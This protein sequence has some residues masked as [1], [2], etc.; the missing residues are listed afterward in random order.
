MITILALLTLATASRDANTFLN[1]TLQRRTL[2]T[3]ATLTLATLLELS[4]RL[5]SLVTIRTLAPKTLVMQSRESLT[6]LWSTLR[7]KRIPTCATPTLAV[8]ESS[9]RLA[10]NATIMMLALL[11]LA[12][13]Q[14][15]SANTRP[16]NATMETLALLILATQQLESASTFQ[17]LVMMET[18]ALKILA[19]LRP[20]SASSLMSPKS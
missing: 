20:E 11:T 8:R 13:Q 6:L 7:D 18:L 16:F 14:L 3:N 17:R 1:M 12:T 4:T 2:R 9:T 19:M 15:E 10:N 5:L